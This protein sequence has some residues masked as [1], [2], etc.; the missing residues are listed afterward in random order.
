PVV[1]PPTSERRVAIGFNEPIGWFADA[2]GV[3]GYLQLG[4]HHGL[5][6]NGAMFPEPHY[7]ATGLAAISADDGGGAEGRVIEAGIGW[8]WYPRQFMDGFST[9]I[10]AFYRHR[11][12]HDYYDGLG[13]AYA[14]KTQMIAARAMIGW[15]WRYEG[16]FASL[17]VGA[18]FGIERGT[19]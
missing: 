3:S 11:D 5:R 10:G 8:N 16:L 14:W 9:E 7:M 12:N 18:S 19:K 1:E 15:T 4:D 2:V 6:V 13:D 17:A